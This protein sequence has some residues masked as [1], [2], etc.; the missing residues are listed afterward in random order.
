MQRLRSIT[1][2]RY[3]RA[4]LRP[5]PRM[6]MADSRVFLKCTR[7]SEPL[8]LAHLVSLRASV[9]YFTIAGEAGEAAR[10]G[11]V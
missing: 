11:A 5:M 3:E 10:R 6:A 2:S 8:A 9:L 7:R 1:A 4:S